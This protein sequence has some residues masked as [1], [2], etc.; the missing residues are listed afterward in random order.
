MSI[1]LSTQRVDDPT[2]PTTQTDT[3]EADYPSTDSLVFAMFVA[4]YNARLSDAATD[5]EFP[6]REMFDTHL[7]DSFRAAYDDI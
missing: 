5:V 1:E 3:A 7:Y 6:D 2:E 4:G